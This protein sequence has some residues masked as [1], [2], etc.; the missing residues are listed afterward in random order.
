M[1]R[2]ARTILISVL[3]VV[4]AVFL[5]RKTNLLP[6]FSDIF[7]AKPVT[8]DQTPVIVKDIREMAQLV[9]LSAYDEV[10][11]DSVRIGPAD[12][13]VHA[14]P[15]PGVNLL[16]PDR[17]VLVGKGRVVAGMDLK[18][19]KEEDIHV[20]KD[21][22]AIRLPSASILEV[23]MNPSDFD[24]FLE[25]GD[26]TPEAV[27]RVKVKARDQLIRRAIDQGILPKAQA[28]GELLMGNF[29][30]AAGY[31]KIAFLK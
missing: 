24:T 31:E 30:H 2:T 22:I 20:T 28:R 15:I 9:T 13:L 8:I 19:L 21:S 29:L 16:T 1:F 25:S 18:A 7:S 4:S 17:I 10:V 27:T 12:M 6:S 14:L 26:W 11:A 5:L 23:V 3:V